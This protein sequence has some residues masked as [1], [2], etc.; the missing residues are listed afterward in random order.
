MSNHEIP[1][2]ADTI[3]AA[4]DAIA[5]LLDNRGKAESG[6]DIPALDKTLLLNQGIA[7]HYR[8]LQGP[9]KRDD[10]VDLVE[11]AKG[12]FRLYMGD[13]CPSDEPFIEGGSSALDIQ[14]GYALVV[15][16]SER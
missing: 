8:E 5:N 7:K 1:T 6:Y 4:A 9:Y 12:L 14:A 2:L 10:D 13:R 15:A 11:F 3:R 16:R